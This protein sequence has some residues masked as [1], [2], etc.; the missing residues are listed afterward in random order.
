MTS[1]PPLPL[2]EI[3]ALLARDPDHVD[4]RYLRA[5]A[6]AGLGRGEEAKRDYLSVIARAPRIG[7]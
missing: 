1:S 2:A 7:S 4:L 6:L 3:E 5:G